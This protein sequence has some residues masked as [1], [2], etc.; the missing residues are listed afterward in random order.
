MGDLSVRPATDRVRQTVFN[1]ISARR[2]IEGTDVLD[3]YAG[4]GSL[5]LEALS[6]GAR[7]VVFVE[8]SGRVA[9]HLEGT[10][11]RFG[12]E[13]ET[14]VYTMDSR[15]YVAG[16]RDRFDLVFADPPYAFPD[17]GR[18]PEWV[19]GAAMLNPGGFLVIEH[20]ATLSFDG[21]GPY[22]ILTER[23]FGRTVVTFFTANS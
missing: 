9:R 4:S 12:C 11:A 3:L 1:I 2:E 10:I 16:T 21:K 20:A 14:D 17:T 6:R 8:D 22:R 18:I 19:A 23:R 15:A 5:G 13:D 7:R